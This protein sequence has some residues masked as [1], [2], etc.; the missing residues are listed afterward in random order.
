MHSI[1]QQTDNGCVIWFTLNPETTG[2]DCRTMTDLVKVENVIKSHAKA[3]WGYNYEELKKIRINKIDIARDHRG[4][5][6]PDVQST[7]FDA[8][9]ETLKD[10]LEHILSYG[11]TNFLSFHTIGDLTI[12]KGQNNLETC[13]QFD[14]KDD[15]GDK[16][17]TVKV[18]DKDIDLISRDGSKMVGSKT[19]AVV[20]SK[21]KMSILNQRLGQA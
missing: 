7:A 13:F 15:D 16:I 20:C 1:Y 6:I 12:T 8:M 2:I 18:Y 10:E 3:Y 5:F 17:L 4:S 21:L 11:E 14:V 9:R 19:N